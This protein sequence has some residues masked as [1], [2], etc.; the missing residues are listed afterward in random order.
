[1]H[2]VLIS[3]G[4]REEFHGQVNG[5]SV[6]LRSSMPRGVLIRR[7]P[8]GFHSVWHIILYRVHLACALFDDILLWREPGGG[9]VRPLFSGVLCFF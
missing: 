7:E 9:R 1:M 6:L 2:G 5:V 4:G 3:V 8:G